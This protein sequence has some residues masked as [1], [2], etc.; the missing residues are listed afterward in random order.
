MKLQE[1]AN[2]VLQIIFDYILCVNDFFSLH[3]HQSISFVL[4]NTQVSFFSQIDESLCP[5]KFMH[6]LDEMGN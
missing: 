4:L 1:N 2:N 3:C 5:Q 6:N